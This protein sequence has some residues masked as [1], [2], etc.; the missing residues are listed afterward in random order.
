VV[1]VRGIESGELEWVENQ[2]NVRSTPDMGRLLYDFI[3]LADG[4]DA[5]LLEFAR[6]WGPLGL[7]REH[8]WPMC[9]S[10]LGAHRRQVAGLGVVCPPGMR[11]EAYCEPLGGRGWEVAPD[12][13]HN[14][15]FYARLAS[16]LM[17]LADALAH[18]DL[19]NPAEWRILGRVPKNTTDAN[20]IL[21]STLALWQKLSDLQP[22][23][24]SPP[25][26]GP[27]RLWLVSGEATC[28]DEQFRL[29]PSTGFRGGLFAAITTALVLLCTGSQGLAY[30]ADCGRMF[31]PARSPARG[32]L[33]F[34]PN[35]GERSA[36]KLSM[37]RARA[38]KRPS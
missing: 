30:C 9:H 12:G 28:L 7:C 19:K 5:S 29:R 2:V 23:V 10:L 6:Q 3:R 13:E 35:C 24:A 34:C 31:Q 33:T 27:L 4:D 32:R 15:R 26:G 18:G 36:R 14:W 38:R 1:E 21:A 11:G 20:G 16:A 17:E 25:T 37:R 8:G 22:V